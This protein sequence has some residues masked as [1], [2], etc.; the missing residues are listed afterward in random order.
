LKGYCSE[1]LKSLLFEIKLE[2]SEIKIVYQL[3]SEQRRSAD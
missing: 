3:L 1:T 2:R